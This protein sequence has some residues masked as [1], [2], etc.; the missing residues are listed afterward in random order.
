ML[1]AS[2]NKG[3]ADTGQ[4]VKESKKSKDPL[5]RVKELKDLLDW[6]KES[7]EYCSQSEHNKNSNI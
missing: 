4:G 1:R 7:K 2:L 3:P 5:A 6:I